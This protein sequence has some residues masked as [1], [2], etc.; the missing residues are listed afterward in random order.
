MIVLQTGGASD[1]VMMAM[2]KLSRNQ[3]LKEL[4]WRMILQVTLRR[5][6][7][8]PLT[9]ALSARACALARAGVS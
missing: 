3:R 1:I 7:A 8:Q 6:G 5:G 4:G 9:P 2:L